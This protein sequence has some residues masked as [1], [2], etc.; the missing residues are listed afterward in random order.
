MAENHPFTFNVM[1]DPLRELRYR[2]TV[3]EG[4]HI[5]TRSPHSYATRREAEREAGE[6]RGKARAALAGWPM[7][8]A[9]QAESVRLDAGHL[10][11]GVR[12]GLPHRRRSSPHPL[13]EDCGI[14][15][16]KS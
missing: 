5:Q 7:T 1:A 4:S 3:C 8:K 15:R 9:A 6:G 16:P 13:I 10:R 12:A 11:R 2:W 14:R